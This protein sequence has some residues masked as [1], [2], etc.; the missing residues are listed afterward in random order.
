MQI[1]PEDDIDEAVNAFL[2]LLQK[3]TFEKRDW[4]NEGRTQT[5]PH[6]RQSGARSRNTYNFS[7]WKLKGKKRLL[8]LT[9]TITAVFGST[10]QALIPIR[11]ATLVLG[12]VISAKAIELGIEQG[13]TEFDF[14]RGNETYKYRFG[15]QDTT[16]YKIDMN[17]EIHSSVGEKTKMVVK[18]KQ[19]V[20]R[21]AMLSVHTCPLA[22]LGGKKN[23]GHERLCS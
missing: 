14:L 9:L 11:L 4:L 23:R 16:I 15:A 19:P 22:M 20:K 3:S 2:E 12:V 8:Y 5:L 6:C 7:L 18:K 21:I 1:G 17:R 10:I 13:A